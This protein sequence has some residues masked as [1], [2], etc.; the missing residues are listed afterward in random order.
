MEELIREKKSSDFRDALYKTVIV[1]LMSALVWWGN[2]F[3]FKIP[4]GGLI[5][6]IHLGN[7]MCVLAGL[8]FG[9]TIGGLASGIGA[10]LFDLLD[11]VFVVSAPYTFFSKFAMGFAAGHFKRSGE[12]SK[13]KV[14]IASV[15]GQLVYIVLYL[16]KTYLSQRLLGEP[17]SVSLTKTGVNAITSSVNG[18]LSVVIAVPLYF[19][20]S[21]ALSHTGMA[22]FIFEKQEKKGYLNPLTAFLT[23]FAVTATAI[24]GINLANMNKQKAAQTEK[25]AAYE[26]KIEDLQSQ[27]DYLSDKLGVEI[28][29]AENIETEE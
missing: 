11:P 9:R 26:Q 13:T 25:E 22:K 14:I 7:S 24:F 18:V 12:E 5:T 29:A 15:I 4:N 1:G 28:P 17:V 16:F 3:Q 10:G 2:Y 27:I 20:L 21:K 19:A 6:R 23:A 8:L